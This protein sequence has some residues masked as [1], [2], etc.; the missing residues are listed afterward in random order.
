[1]PI[2]FISCIYFDHVLGVPYDSVRTINK[3]P[4]GYFVSLYTRFGLRRN[5]FIETG[6]QGDFFFIRLSVQTIYCLS[7]LT[8]FQSVRGDPTSRR[9]EDELRYEWSEKA[10]ER[11]RRKGGSGREK[12]NMAEKRKKGKKVQY[13]T[14]FKVRN[15]AWGKWEYR[16]VGIKEGGEDKQDGNWQEKT[17]PTRPTSKFSIK[18]NP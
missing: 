1:M 9:R 16:N 7:S 12:I 8:H 15:D 5:S 11:E 6:T 10:G 4:F 13:C 18:L 3:N 17:N 14:G 2:H